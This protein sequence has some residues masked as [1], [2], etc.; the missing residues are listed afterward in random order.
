ML[1]TKLSPTLC[2]QLYNKFKKA[3]PYEVIWRSLFYRY[4]TPR[5]VKRQ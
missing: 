1:N 4:Y 2:K 3:L 5:N